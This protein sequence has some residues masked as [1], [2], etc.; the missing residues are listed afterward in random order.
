MV[1]LSACTYAPRYDDPPSAYRHDYYFYPHVGVYFHLHSGHYYY[2]DGPSWVRA[3]VLPRHIF[4]DHRVRRALVIRDAAPYRHHETHR[5]RYR[6][7]QDFKHD[8]QRD[9][10]EREHNHRRHEDYRRR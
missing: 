10:T 2:R 9:R 3:R 7:P 4:L 8:R 5:E 6:A 1:G